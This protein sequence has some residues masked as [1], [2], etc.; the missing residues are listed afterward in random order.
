MAET[1][2]IVM[3]THL[4]LSL[5]LILYF[6]VT[7]ACNTMTVGLCPIHYKLTLFISFIIRDKRDDPPV[8]L[9]QRG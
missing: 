5:S 2:C 8:E 1:Y 7:S 6:L 4:A 3:H 9:L